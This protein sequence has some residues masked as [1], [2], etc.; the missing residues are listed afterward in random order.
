MTL[1][2]H[3]SFHLQLFYPTRL[4]PFFLNRLGWC[5]ILSLISN[6]LGLLHPTRRRWLSQVHM[7]RRHRRR[8]WL[9]PPCWALTCLQ[10]RLRLHRLFSHLCRVHRHLSHNSRPRCQHPHT[11]TL[12]LHRNPCIHLSHHQNCLISAMFWTLTW[13][14]LLP[15]TLPLSPPLS[16]SVCQLS[17][18]MCLLSFT[19]MRSLRK[20]STMV[21]RTHCRRCHWLT[22]TALMSISMPTHSI[23]TPT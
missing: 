19:L 8:S 23:A 4:V 15:L 13:T 6:H 21:T 16:L 17:L 22:F 1:K 18:L 9:M 20:G 3:W 11:S 5:C 10:L 2:F 7:H 12:R 14:T